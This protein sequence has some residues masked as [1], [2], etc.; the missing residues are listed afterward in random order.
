MRM[1]T[2]E[3]RIEDAKRGTM[4]IGIT[5][6]Q[7]GMTEEQFGIIKEMMELLF[8]TEIHAGDCVG[9]DAECITLVKE[10]RPEVKTVGHP[11]D[12]DEKRAFLEYDE[13]REAKAP[14]VRNRDIVD[15]SEYLFACPKET[16][17]VL[18]SG[19]WATIRYARKV[20]K[21]VL[22][23]YPDGTVAA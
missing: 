7:E 11:C 15:E 13:E 1:K 16:E 5:G 3:E 21:Q 2:L 6:T 4:S 10:L 18:R 8:M 23:I 14:L 20:G 22:I 9:F 17:E 19:T 12:I